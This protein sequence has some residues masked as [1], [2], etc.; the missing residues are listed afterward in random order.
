MKRAYCSGCGREVRLDERGMCPSRHP[1][2]WY[3]NVRDDGR[4]A[5]PPPEI[6]P[7][8]APVAPAAP[9]EPVAPVTSAAPREPVAPVAVAVTG[10]PVAPLPVQQPSS[11]WPAIVAIAAVFVI[12]SCG[13]A[14]LAIPL[15]SR[16]ARSV[17]VAS[18][19][20]TPGSHLSTA[21]LEGTRAASATAPLTGKVKL[22]TL[23]AGPYP[24][25]LTPDPKHRTPSN[26]QRLWALASASLDAACDGDSHET[27]AAITPEAVSVKR[28]GLAQY[29]GVTSRGTLLATLT[30]IED[31]GHRKGFDQIASVI[32]SAPPDQVQ[33]LDDLA[34]T[35]PQLANYVDVVR[36]HSAQLG[37]KSIVGWDYVRYIEL[38]RWGYACGYLSEDEAWQRIMPAARALQRTFT[39]WQDIADD[40]EI[41][42]K[43][44]SLAE[45]RQNYAQMRWAYQTLRDDPKSPW[46]TVPWNTD[47]TPGH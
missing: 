31:G 2:H 23:K 25:Y 12:F 20:A 44:W 3:R 36:A 42:Y 34:G 10:E 41:G 4:G 17:V 38:C 22:P 5:P 45:T 8:R 46:H 47:L 18:R 37:A 6:R 35:D 33:R 13:A 28:Q 39:S 27:L 32:A 15:I 40:Y 29:W 9:R 14:A 19:T 1:T 26:R 30:W 24:P 16:A 7:A 43:F 11:A 21:T